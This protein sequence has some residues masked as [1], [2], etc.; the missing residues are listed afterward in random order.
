MIAQL[1]ANLY[2]KFANVD[3]SGDQCSMRVAI[4]FGKLLK[5]CRSACLKSLFLCLSGILEPPG[6]TRGR[7]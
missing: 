5:V 6:A 1:D 3:P 7:L 2:S 4:V